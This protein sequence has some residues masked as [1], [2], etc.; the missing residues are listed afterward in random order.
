M[1]YASDYLGVKG[2]FFKSENVFLVTSIKQ[3]TVGIKTRQSP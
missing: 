2:Q 1:G 3:A